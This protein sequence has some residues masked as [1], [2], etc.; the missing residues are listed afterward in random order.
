MPVGRLVAAGAA[1]PRKRPRLDEGV[2]PGPAVSGAPTR[3]P[4]WSS[5]CR[6]NTR[7]GC[8]TGT[9]ADTMVVGWTAAVQDRL[10]AGLSDT[11]LGRRAVPRRPGESGGSG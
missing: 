7:L 2:V 9:A 1:V 11:R 10:H 5:L 3:W 6:S 8:L 4:S